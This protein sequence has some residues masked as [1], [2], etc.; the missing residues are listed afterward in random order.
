ME[1]YQLLTLVAAVLVAGRLASVQHTDQSA[2]DM[3]ATCLNQAWNM[4]H[5]ARFMTRKSVP[6]DKKEDVV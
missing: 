1:D 6:S 5:T 4:I 3:N 2:E